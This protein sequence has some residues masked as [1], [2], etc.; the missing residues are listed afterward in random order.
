MLKLQKVFLCLW[1]NDEAD[2]L[3]H[4]E[5]KR[6]QSR[7]YRCK[8]KHDC[9]QKVIAYGSPADYGP[10]VKKSV[11]YQDAFD[12]FEMVT[13]KDGGRGM[14]WSAVDDSRRNRQWRLASLHMSRRQPPK[15]RAEDS[16]RLIAAR[17]HTTLAVWCLVERLIV[18][19]IIA[20]EETAAF[21][22]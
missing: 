12:L 19:I 4:R 18:E 10:P 17:L 20:F 1:R 11:L 9:E 13:G 6:R 7:F 2:L 5:L 22:K 16:A 8:N 21:E 15:P 14:G 3:G